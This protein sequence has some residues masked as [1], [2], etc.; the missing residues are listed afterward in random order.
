MPK[1][2][3]NFNGKVLL[4]YGYCSNNNNITQN[5]LDEVDIFDYC[6][7]N[8]IINNDN[9]I[10]VLHS[11]K[12][13]YEEVD[14]VECVINDNILNING[15]LYKYIKKDDIFMNINLDKC[16]E[17]VRIH[18][19]YDTCFSCKNTDEIVIPY[20]YGEN[21]I[22]NNCILDNIEYH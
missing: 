4:S 5:D 13:T 20:C 7:N 14:I 15:E 21:W 12:G 18:A 11:L 2:S 16:N 10:E 22:C 1:P 19:I 9:N 8:D 17:F 6:K 3:K